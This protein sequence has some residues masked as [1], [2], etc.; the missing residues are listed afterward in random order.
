M[1]HP[2]PPPVPLKPQRVLRCCRLALIAIILRQT[3]HMCLESLGVCFRANVWHG[4]HPRMLKSTI[5]RSVVLLLLSEKGESVLILLYDYARYINDKRVLSALS[6]PHS[7]SPVARVRT[8]QSAR[9][10]SATIG[11]RR[12]NSSSWILSTTIA[13]TPI[14]HNYS[15]LSDLFAVKGTNPALK[16]PSNIPEIYAKMFG[17][18]H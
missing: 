5:C 6:R 4:I 18:F 2:L 12:L 15:R 14:N 8:S 16:K 9:R 10:L 17:R 1:T 7:S 11:E 3:V 13:S